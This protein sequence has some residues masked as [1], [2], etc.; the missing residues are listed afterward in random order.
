VRASGE[1]ADL[2]RLLP[3]MSW[4]GAFGIRRRRRGSSAAQ[5]PGGAPLAAR[6]VASGSGGRG[7]GRARPVARD[8]TAV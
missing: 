7:P 1:R 3:L 8:R 4:L 5:S 2:A 6:R